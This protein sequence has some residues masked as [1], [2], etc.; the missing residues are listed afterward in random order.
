MSKRYP[1]EIHIF[2][3]VRLRDEQVRE[4]STWITRDLLNAL[5]ISLCE[6]INVRAFDIYERLGRHHKS[7]AED[8]EGDK[9][10][11]FL[12]AG[13][14]DESLKGI[15]ETTSEPDIAATEDREGK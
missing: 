5:E 14:H 2:I 10:L 12:V 11:S 6:N 9:L 8:F 3:R 4:K 15:F 13:Q 1:N 7:F